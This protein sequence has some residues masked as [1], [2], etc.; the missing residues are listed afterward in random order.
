MAKHLNINV[1]SKHF[2]HIEII[3]E[4]IKFKNIC[5]VSCLNEGFLYGGIGLIKSIRKFYTKDQAE[6]IIFVDK[7]IS[8]LEDLR[9]TLHFKIEYASNIYNWCAKYFN[10]TRFLNDKTHFYHPQYKPII[11]NN[12]PNESGFGKIRHLHPLN[13]KA[14]CTGFAILEN[15]YDVIIHIDSDA[16]LLSKIDS[17]Y[18]FLQIE[19]TIV[20]FDDLYTGWQDNFNKLYGINIIGINKMKYSLNAG[21]VFYRNGKMI[22]ELIKDFMWYIESCV[23]FKHSGLKDQGV[24]QSL[25]AK[26][27]INN[28]INLFV[29]DA[30]NWNPTWNRADN[31]FYKN[32]DWINLNNNKKQII[33][34]GAGSKKL[35]QKHYGSISVTNAWNWVNS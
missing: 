30:T 19:N 22:K 6:I 18:R 26:Y 21:V 17:I 9:S 11:D 5:F 7:Y 13:L 2:K 24:L 31:L 3:K 25:I 28:M 27:H 33:W 8:K 1:R 32:G 12:T 14:Y 10:N 15:N 4:E 20:G 23:H 29:L 34:H 35:W 16:F